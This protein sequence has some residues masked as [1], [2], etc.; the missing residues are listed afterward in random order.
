MADFWASLNSTLANPWGALGVAVLVG[1][2]LFLGVVGILLWRAKPGSTQGRLTRRIMT[3][4]STIYWPFLA[5]VVWPNALFSAFFLG[6]FALELWLNFNPGRR[7][8]DRWLESH[9][10]A[11]DADRAE[12]MARDEAERKARYQ[13]ELADIDKAEEA[14]KSPA[15][16]RSASTEETV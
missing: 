7:E 6:V 16:A 1:Y 5:L 4:G 12:H 10:A 13:Q 2:A 8:R 14:A 3:L 11:V 15:A 9:F